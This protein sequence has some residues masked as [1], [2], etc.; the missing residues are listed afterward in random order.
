MLPEKTTFYSDLFR[1]P[2][3]TL[4]DSI[5][6]Y[7]FKVYIVSREFAFNLLQAEHTHS[8]LLI[9]IQFNFIKCIAGKYA[10]LLTTTW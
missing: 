7:N 5:S 6:K 1:L 2:K 10:K 9:H 3:E 4:M 8:N